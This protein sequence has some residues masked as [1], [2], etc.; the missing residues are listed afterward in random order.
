MAWFENL[1]WLVTVVEKTK[2]R[3]E[4]VDR[5]AQNFHICPASDKVKTN[6][7]C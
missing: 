6:R 3:V 1:R 5:M 2:N 7:I 4:S